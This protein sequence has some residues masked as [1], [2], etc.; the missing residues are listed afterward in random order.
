MFKNEFCVIHGTVQGVTE[1]VFTRWRKDYQNISLPPD[2]SSTTSN[3]A[4]YLLTREEEENLALSQ[5]KIMIPISLDTKDER[6]KLNVLGKDVSGQF[7]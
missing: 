1:M 3:D 2:L 4:K 7:S 6:K 5:P